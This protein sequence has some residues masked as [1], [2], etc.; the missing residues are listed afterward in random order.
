MGAV[1]IPFD[2]EIQSLSSFSLALLLLLSSPRATYAL[3][4]SGRCDLLDSST[5][6]SMEARQSQEE[7]YSVSVIDGAERVSH[8]NAKE[9]CSQ[10]VIPQEGEDS[11]R[12]SLRLERSFEIKSVQNK[13]QSRV[14][15]DEEVDEVLILSPKLRSKTTLSI[16]EEHSEC[17]ESP[18]YANLGISS[19]ELIRLVTCDLFSETFLARLHAS[20]S[21]YFVKVYNKS[22]LTISGIL[23]RAGNEQ[24]ALQLLAATNDDTTWAPRLMWS[25]QDE[26]SLY[27]VTDPP[28]QEYR[29]LS[30]VKDSLTHSQICC[31]SAQ[32]VEIVSRLHMTGIVHGAIEPSHILIS[33]PGQILLMG[34][35]HCS[36]DKRTIDKHDNNLCFEGC[37]TSF[38]LLSSLAPEVLLGWERDGKI[39]VW[40]VGI[41]LFLM[42]TTEHPFLEKTNE[43]N[44]LRSCILHATL[45]SE[46]LLAADAN[47]AAVDLIERC[48]QRN[49]SLRPSIDGI[50]SHGYFS[51]IDWNTILHDVNGEINGPIPP[52][53]LDSF[54]LMKDSD[55]A[56]QESGEH[57]ITNFHL[58]NFDYSR[59]SK[60][61]K[62]VELHEP[63]TRLQPLRQSHRSRSISSESSMSCTSFGELILPSRNAMDLGSFDLTPTRSPSAPRNCPVSSLDATRTHSSVTVNEARGLGLRKYASLNFDSDTIVSLPL[64]P[65]D[66]HRS[67]DSQ[68][69]S[70]C[71]PMV[72]PNKASTDS[73]A[74]TLPL[75]ALP[76]WSPLKNLRLPRAQAT[77]SSLA[78]PQYSG[79]SNDEDIHDED[80]PSSSP[81]AP[82]KLRKKTRTPRSS[83]T[84]NPPATTPPP[85]NMKPTPILDLPKG[86][87]QIG[88]GIGF[89]FPFKRDNADSMTSIIPRSDA[90]TNQ[91]DSEITPKASRS[92]SFGLLADGFTGNLRRR[93]VGKNIKAKS[94]TEDIQGRPVSTGSEGDAMEAVM[95][96]MY[97]STWD[98]N[99]GCHVSKPFD[100]KDN[101]GPNKIQVKTMP[102]PPSRSTLA[103]A[104][105]G[106]GF[107]SGP[108]KA[109]AASTSALELFNDTDCFGPIH[110][111]GGDASSGSM[112][113]LASK[114]G[115]E[116]TAVPKRL[117]RN[118]VRWELDEN[119]GNGIDNMRGK[120]RVNV[121][122]NMSRVRK[123]A[124]VDGSETLK[125]LGLSANAT[126]IMTGFC[127]DSL[128]VVRSGY[129]CSIYFELKHR[130][131]LAFHTLPE[132]CTSQLF[133]A[134]PLSIQMLRAKLRRPD[135]SYSHLYS[136]PTPNPYLLR[137]RKDTHSFMPLNPTT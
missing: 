121:K 108:M 28:P 98:L 114:I 37:T 36:V 6:Q 64:S 126:V 118:S 133:T 73:G 134:S 9:P 122:K 11:D 18:D 113:L 24:R 40:G 30:Q 29:T 47:L 90:A 100:T 35:E 10:I 125:K 136:H 67:T 72:S 54:D 84:P 137:W 81:F 31:I 75:P 23:D 21:N 111:V 1:G 124:S 19:F 103:Q 55:R 95:K 12:K 105:L 104:G 92:V 117:K 87:E 3:R 5:V 41:I 27:I 80:Q 16:I 53:S 2:A 62:E 110:Q 123:R 56:T 70:Y 15:D 43:Y 115:T 86:I 130:R 109:K 88:N 51:N 66:V 8:S 39:D 4:H 65:R 71:F 13:G 57:R 82:N 127:T 79:Q 85:F 48:L 50:K 58:E 45:R 99:L 131:R 26:E 60:S 68:D 135:N 22:S 42:F 119:H 49:P 25:F 132:A 91:L 77:S 33:G 44:H 74:K 128:C 112:P 96:E 14:W 76:L 120:E 93:F 107:Q 106:F 83:S 129:S 32:L 69:L 78:L 34:F 102:R 97:G 59:S 94:S 89:T 20:P 116:S 101:N 52:A 38:D 17:S 61:S 46:A 63:E 7:P